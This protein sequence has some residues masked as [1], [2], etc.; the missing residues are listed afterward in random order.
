M[1]CVC[2]IGRERRQRDK[3]GLRERKRKRRNWIERERE[4]L[5]GVG[6]SVRM[7]I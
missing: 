1:C 6:E 3:E 5:R 2:E 4:S 7:L